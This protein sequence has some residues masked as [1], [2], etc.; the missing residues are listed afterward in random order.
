MPAAC[1]GGVE[2]LTA[3]RTGRILSR[4]IHALLR[5][6]QV[7]RDADEVKN[8][9]RQYRVHRHRQAR[10][11]RDPEHV[12]KHLAGEVPCGARSCAVAARPTTCRGAACAVTSDTGSP[13]LAFVIL[14]LSCVSAFSP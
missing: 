8:D 13:R 12:R 5:K 7:L 1:E 10:A 6:K 2:A 9:G 3:G 4:E 14:T 11:G